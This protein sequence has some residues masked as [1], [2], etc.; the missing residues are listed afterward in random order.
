MQRDYTC[1]YRP[2]YTDPD[3]TP[4]NPTV[5][6]NYKDPN[7]TPTYLSVSPGAPFEYPAFQLGYQ[8]QQQPPPDI[9]QPGQ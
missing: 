5:K 4:V 9:S 8:P 1:P 7:E 3:A 2:T 6:I